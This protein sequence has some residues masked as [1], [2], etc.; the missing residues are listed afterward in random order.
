MLCYVKHR[1]VNVNTDISQ[2]LWLS[3]VNILTRV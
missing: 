1:Q 2:I 3:R